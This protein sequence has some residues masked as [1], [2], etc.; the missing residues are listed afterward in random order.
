MVYR[1]GKLRMA[2][3]HLTL[4]AFWSMAALLAVALFIECFVL[5]GWDAGRAGV[6]LATGLLT[7]AAVRMALG[8]QAW[9]RPFRTNLVEIDE[10]GIRLR[11]EGEAEI[12]VAWQDVRSIKI[13]KRTATTGG[14]WQFPYRVE[15]YIISTAC[16]PL[17][18][19][20][21]DIPR[22]RRAARE[23]AEGAGLQSVRE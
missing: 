9:I 16:G 3:W 20:S 14:F 18:F 13:E 10:T 1:R 6:T 8:V 11:L 4:G 23:I 17:T 12:R 21:V 19:T 22:A 5:H 15:E 2:G 7:F